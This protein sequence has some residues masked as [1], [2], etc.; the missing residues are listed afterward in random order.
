MRFNPTL[1]AATAA[2]VLPLAVGCTSSGSDGAAPTL[3]PSPTVQPATHGPM[4]PQCGGISD[5]TIAE[6]TRV[7]GLVNT[8]QTSVGC[9]WL[10][11]GGII[12]PHFSF[13]WYR[14]SPIGRERKTEELTRSSVED[15]TIGGYDGFIA[16]GSMPML[17]D[18]LCEIGIQFDDDFIEWSVSFDKEPYPDP[19]E[20]ATELTSQTIA[21]AR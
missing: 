17:G 10:A 4:F 21:N 7:S 13:S 15:I 9:Q 2:M 12:G 14:G 6:L 8:A 16:I 11:N 20:V 5:E 19:C 1:W 18:S 3:A